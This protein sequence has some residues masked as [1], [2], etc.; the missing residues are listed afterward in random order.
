M[1][2]LIGTSYRNSTIMKNANLLDDSLSLSHV[3][4]PCVLMLYVSVKT[5][6]SFSAIYDFIN[7]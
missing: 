7:H 4:M 5:L 3:L 1:K 6:K 2:G